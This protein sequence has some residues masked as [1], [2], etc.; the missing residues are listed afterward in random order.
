MRTSVFNLSFIRVV[1]QDYVQPVVDL[2]RGAVQWQG[3]SGVSGERMRRAAFGPEIA[4]S[5]EAK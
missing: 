3:G 2:Q 4:P 1:D 5:G